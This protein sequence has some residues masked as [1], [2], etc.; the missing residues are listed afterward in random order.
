NELRYRY[1]SQTGGEAVFSEV[2]YPDGWTLTLENG[3]ELAITLEEEVLRGASLP[4]GEHELTMHFL[5]RSYYV[6]ERV[7]LASS[8]LLIL[9]VLLSVAG[10]IFYAK[11]DGSQS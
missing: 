7:S 11:K 2:Y 8:I 1:D 4:A 6:G 10:S 5:P 9:L 3:E